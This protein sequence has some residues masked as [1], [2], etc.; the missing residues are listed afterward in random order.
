MS[1]RLDELHALYPNY[2]EIIIYEPDPT[3]L[4]CDG[5]GRNDDI[6]HPCACTVY[7]PTELKQFRDAMDSI[8][9]Q[10]KVLAEDAIELERRELS[11]RNN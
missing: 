11:A 3:C 2:A 5:T 8:L 10:F 1:A 9:S 4:A 7:S 6:G